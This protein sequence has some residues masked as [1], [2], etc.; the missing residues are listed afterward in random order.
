MGSNGRCYFKEFVHQLIVGGVFRLL[1]PSKG[2][3]ELRGVDTWR[4]EAGVDLEV[5]SHEGV[6]ICSS[7][8]VPFLA[9]FLLKGSQLLYL[10]ASLCQIQPKS[11]LLQ[12]QEEGLLLRLEEFEGAVGA[13]GGT[14][15][16]SHESSIELYEGITHVVHSLLRCTPS[17]L[18][19]LRNEFL[20]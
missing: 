13:G 17:F 16:V 18:L 8:L 7:P 6:N 1:R 5:L 3:V 4:D 15:A 20:L 11:L 19:Y 2:L 9:V 12:A 14:R 10:S